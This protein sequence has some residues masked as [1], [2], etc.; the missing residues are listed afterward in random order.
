MMQIVLVEPNKAAR[1]V[2]I[3]DNLHAMQALVGG[4]IQALYPWE[5]P[6]ALICNDEGKILGLPLNRVLGD[7]EIIAGTFFICGIQGENFSG[8]TEQQIQK[9]QQM[10]RSPEKFINTPGGILCIRMNPVISPERK[11][12]ALRFGLQQS[13]R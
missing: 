9:Y 1:P 4:P 12:N 3:E 11:A 7:Y 10:F 8:L 5:D 2:E 6:V 13:C